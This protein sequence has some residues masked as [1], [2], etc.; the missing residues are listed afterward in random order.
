VK[1]PDAEVEASLLPAETEIVSSNLDSAQTAQL[2]D[3]AE[4]QLRLAVAGDAGLR[5][6][7][8]EAAIRS[9]SGLLTA[10][11]FKDILVY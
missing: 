5:R 6:R 1:L 11:G 7:A 8:H 4:G 3:Q 9:V 2:L 10:L